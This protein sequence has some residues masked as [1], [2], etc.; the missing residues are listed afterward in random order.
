M[1]FLV[2]FSYN[3]LLNQFNLILFFHN[4]FNEKGFYK[5]FQSFLLVKIIE[6]TKCL[7]HYE[8][9]RENAKNSDEHLDEGRMLRERTLKEVP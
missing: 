7:K 2:F 9:S 8:N 4:Y 5:I 3:L 6:I 1:F